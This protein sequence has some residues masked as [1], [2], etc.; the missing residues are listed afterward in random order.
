MSRI[1]AN[2]IPYWSKAGKTREV[3]EEAFRDFQA[4]GFTATKADVPDG[5]TVDEYREWI[6]GF[7]LFLLNYGP[8]LLKP[9][10]VR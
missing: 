3:F 10:D 8:F 1:A 5:M 7:G 6:A 9:R 4:I 2:P